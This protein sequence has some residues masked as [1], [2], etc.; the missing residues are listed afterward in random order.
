[1]SYAILIIILILIVLL[2]SVNWINKC[3][4]DK[5]QDNIPEE[6]VDSLDIPTPNL[7]KPDA[8]KLRAKLE[9]N[10]ATLY[11]LPPTIGVKSLKYYV[12]CLMKEGN[13]PK[14]IFP[15]E[16]SCV[17]CKYVF[18]NLEYDIQYKFSIFAV[19]M[20][21]V[22]KMS[23]IITLKPVNPYKKPEKPKPKKVIKNINC[24]PDG[25]YSLDDYC[26]KE[27]FQ[28]SNLDDST[29]KMLMNLL[30]KKTKNLNFDIKIF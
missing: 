6:E 28:K 17:Y 18:D 15:K 3:N 23:N 22:G 25:T 8:I 12:I 21:G 16:S 10:I 11:W 7:E 27:P 30:V 29:H 9:N 5:F 26:Y 20:E 2:L 13:P 4:Y 14:F 24:H 19:N 1:M